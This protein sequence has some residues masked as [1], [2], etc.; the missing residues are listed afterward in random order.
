ME[1]RDLNI[2]YNKNMETPQV[3][4]LLDQNGKDTDKGLDITPDEK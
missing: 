1:S 2:K 4:V 3:Y